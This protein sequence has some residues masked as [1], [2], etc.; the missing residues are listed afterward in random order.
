[1]LPPFTVQSEDNR[2]M[3][4]HCSVGIEPRIS[5]ER[6]ILLDTQVRHFFIYIIEVSFINSI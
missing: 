3:A 5:A 2:A 6:L 4:R 1:M